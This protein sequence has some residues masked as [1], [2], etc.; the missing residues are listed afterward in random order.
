MKIFIQDEMAHNDNRPWESSPRL[1][2]KFEMRL[3][4]REIL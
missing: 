4:G 2:K 1:N 3:F